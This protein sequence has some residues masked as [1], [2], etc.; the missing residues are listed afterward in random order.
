MKGYPQ[1]TIGEAF[2]HIWVRNFYDKKSGR[3]HW[4]NIGHLSLRSLNFFALSLFIIIASH[5]ATLAGVNFGIIASCLCISTP[6]NCFFSYTYFGEKISTKDI[7]GTLIILIGVVWLSLAKGEVLVSEESLL[8]T[9]E[10]RSLYKIASI[11]IA[12]FVGFINSLRT[13]QAKYVLKK[14]AYSP[15]DFS[16]DG[17]LFTGIV[18][19]FFAALFWLTGNPAYTWYNFLVSFAASLFLMLTSIIGLNAMVKGLAGPTSAILSAN[20]I[21]QTLLNAL[22][23]GLIPS[24][25]QTVGSLIAIGGVVTMVLIK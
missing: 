9:E 6:F 10:A 22:V 12:V 17:G 23:L 8:L 24:I 19:A 18:L 25:M 3:L 20:S 21:V 7:A 16:I 13:F 5:F 15:L 11:C 4:A 2:C 14:Y 1:A